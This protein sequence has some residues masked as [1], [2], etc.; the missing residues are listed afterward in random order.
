MIR[1]QLQLFSTE[2]YPTAAKRPRYSVLDT[3]KTQQTFDEQMPFWKDSLKK[4]I[5]NIK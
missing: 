3:S 2:N 4:A 5:K 1:N